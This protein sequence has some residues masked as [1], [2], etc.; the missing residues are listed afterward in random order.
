MLVS[1]RFRLA[2]SNFPDFPPCLH[3]SSTRTITVTTTEYHHFNSTHQNPKST[4]GT[5]PATSARKGPT[6]GEIHHESDPNESS[7]RPLRG[8]VDGQSLSGRI[9]DRRA[10]AE[11]GAFSALH[12]PFGQVRL[13]E[14]GSGGFGLVG[15]EHWTPLSSGPELE[16][17]NRY[18]VTRAEAR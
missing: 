9:V 18:S 13:E 12:C 6:G 10:L 17:V 14:G 16:S 15:G 8:A 5:T 1:E 4:V 7:P 3:R 2:L 11:L